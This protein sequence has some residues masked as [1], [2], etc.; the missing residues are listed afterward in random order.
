MAA[1]IFKFVDIDLVDIKYQ[2]A[3]DIYARANKEY[4]AITCRWKTFCKNIHRPLTEDEEYK[5]RDEICDAIADVKRSEDILDEAIDEKYP[6]GKYPFEEYQ[7]E[8][9]EKNKNKVFEKG[10]SCNII[11][12]IDKNKC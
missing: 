5:E 1:N 12:F 8:A 7:S 11:I 3:Q 2:R 6:S 9:S 4:Y 10:K